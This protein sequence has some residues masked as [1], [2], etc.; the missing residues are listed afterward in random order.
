MLPRCVSSQRNSEGLSYGIERRLP[1]L[2][3]KGREEHGSFIEDLT[4]QERVPRPTCFTSV[5]KQGVV[6]LAVGCV[7]RSTEE[8]LSKKANVSLIGPQRLGHLKAR[9]ILAKG[10]RRKL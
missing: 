9:P 4:W 8:P 1:T 3:G 2:G 7:Y 5:Q 6:C 10:A